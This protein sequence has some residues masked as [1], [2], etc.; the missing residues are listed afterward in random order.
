MP[1][2]RKFEGIGSPCQILAEVIR[3]AMHDLFHSKGPWV[4]K[5]PTAEDEHVNELTNGAD[6]EKPC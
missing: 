5:G 6:Y 2:E 4:Y 1:A 3:V